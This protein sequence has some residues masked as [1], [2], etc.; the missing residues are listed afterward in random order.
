MSNKQIKKNVRK[1]ENY[2]SQA[3]EYQKL[4]KG[5]NRVRLVSYK[6]TDSFH[7]YDGTLKDV[8]PKFVNATEQLIITVVAIIAGLGGLT[9]RLNLDAYLRWKDLSQ[10]EVDS[11]KFVEIPEGDEI[12]AGAIDPKTKKL[13]RLTDE[14]RTKTCIGILDQMMAAMQVPIGSGIE[15]LDDVIAEKRE[16]IV[17]VAVTEYQGKKQHRILGFKKA[18]LATAPAKETSDLES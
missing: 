4:P 18:A 8:L 11:G 15:V 1:L 17:N 2:Q 3:P 10:A 5:D 14:G 9:H 16:F 7:N 13:V 12:Y 6:A